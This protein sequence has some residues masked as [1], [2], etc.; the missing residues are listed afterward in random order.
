M[1]PF[2][3]KDYLPT[4]VGKHRSQGNKNHLSSNFF[5]LKKKGY[6][7]IESFALYTDELKTLL[8]KYKQ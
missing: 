6:W 4:G 8:G 3:I 1:T 2:S 5:P 7:A